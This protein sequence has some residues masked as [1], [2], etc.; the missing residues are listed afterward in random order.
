MVED[1]RFLK[2]YIKNLNIKIKYF[3]F[4]K[5]K[6]LKNKKE[7]QITYVLKIKVY[8]GAGADPQYSSIG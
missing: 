1:M 6:F 8:Y 3:I 4:H 2:I 5:F 7:V